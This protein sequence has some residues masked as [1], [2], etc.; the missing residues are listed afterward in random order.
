M[1]CK[2]TIDMGLRWWIELETETGAE[3]PFDYGQH[4]VSPRA[5]SADGHVSVWPVINGDLS[6]C[7][8]RKGLRSVVLGAELP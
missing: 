8:Q 1:L 5:W 6:N 7:G 4:E 2:P 3:K